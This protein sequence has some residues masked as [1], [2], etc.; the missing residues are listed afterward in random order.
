MA[1][2]KVYYFSNALGTSGIFTIGEIQWKINA[3]GP[4]E[5]SSLHLTDTV[6]GDTV[7]YKAE[8]SDLE[9]VSCFTSA[10]QAIC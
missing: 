9:K 3:F 4:F 5:K 10:A 1:T 6:I 7:I 8:Q 2:E